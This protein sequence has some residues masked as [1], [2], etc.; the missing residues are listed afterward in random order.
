LTVVG[1]FGAEGSR[2][3]ALIR[4]LL[5]ARFPE[6]DADSS[7]T[8]A[9]RRRRRP[10]V[11]TR[12]TAEIRARRRELG[13]EARRTLHPDE[14]AFLGTLPEDPAALTYEQVQAVRSVT[15][16]A[17]VEPAL[18]FLKSLLSHAEQIEAA[19]DAPYRHLLDEREQITGKLGRQRHPDVY[20]A[21]LA[22]A[23]ATRL[24]EHSADRL[25][26]EVRERFRRIHPTAI[27]GE[28]ALRIAAQEQ[29]ELRKVEATANEMRRNRATYEAEMAETID[30]ERSADATRRN[31]EL[32]LR[33][34]AIDAELR[35]QGAAVLE[36]EEQARRLDD[37]REHYGPLLDLNGSVS[38]EPT[39]T[40]IDGTTGAA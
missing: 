22:R 21:R 31:R 37:L 36:R 14:L 25:R 6:V 33:R 10:P 4:R 7:T 11:P 3:A 18:P 24:I 8:A 34:H 26:E 35:R 19:H 20:A 13:P 29:V 16:R 5:P 39:P 15:R 9:T 38:V 27:N 17:G 28:H 30:S 32:S 2:E 1:T 12:T 23:Q 40:E